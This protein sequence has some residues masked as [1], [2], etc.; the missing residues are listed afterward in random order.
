VRGG[1]AKGELS[2]ACVQSRTVPGVIRTLRH[3]SERS[4]RTAVH[5]PTQHGTTHSRTT[6]SK[7][8]QTEGRSVWPRPLHASI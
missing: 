7:K 4:G 2:W 5:R 1:V 6:A 8:A 3:H